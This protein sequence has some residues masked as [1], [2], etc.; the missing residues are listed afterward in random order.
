MPYTCLA[1]R[2]ART[3][4][5]HCLPARART[6]AR[7]R[8][9][10]R[11][12]L[13]QELSVHSGPEDL[14]GE[15][16][17]L[18]S[19]GLPPGLTAPSDTDTLEEE[20]APAPPGRTRTRV[21]VPVRVR[22]PA[23]VRVPARVCACTCLHSCARPRLRAPR[24][25]FS[26][27]AACAPE[28]ECL[29]GQSTACARESLLALWLPARTRLTTRALKALRARTWR[30]YVVRARRLARGIRALD[31]ARELHHKKSLVFLI[32]YWLDLRA[33]RDQ[34]R[35]PQSTRSFPLGQVRAYASVLE[36][37]I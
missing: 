36:S 30:E 20:K 16:G 14:P 2:G 13:A 32:T 12:A 15:R 11:P 8:R 26:A 6:P 19:P 4:Q 10:K 22:T 21:R 3:E 29:S 37:Y 1:L 31:E 5:A 17:R 24:R 33:S 18:R 28:W 34:A 25:A 9:P 23:R 35:H 7:G 27:H